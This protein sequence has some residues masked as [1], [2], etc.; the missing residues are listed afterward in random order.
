MQRVN[1]FYMSPNPYGGWVTFTAHLMT[2]LLRCGVDAHLFKIGNNTE[3][4]HRPFGYGKFYQNISLADA[5]MLD[6]E[7]LIVAMARNYVEAAAKL[8]DCNSARI[9]IHDPTELKHKSIPTWFLADHCRE[10]MV[11]IRKSMLKV[12]PGATYIP[13]PFE[14]TTTTRKVVKLKNAVSTCRID[15]DKHTEILLTANRLLPE[16]KRI[17]IRGF[18]N[19]LYTKFKIVP[20]FPEWVQSKAHYDR[21]QWGSVYEILRPATYAVDMSEIKGDG[22]GTQYSFLEAI[23]AGCVLVLNRKWMFDKKTDVMQ[24]DENCFM[25]SSGEEL[26]SLLEKPLHKDKQYQ[27]TQ[28]AEKILA[29]HEPKLIGTEYMRFLGG[30]R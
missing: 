8:I 10:K 12:L 6:G 20:N 21:S 25:V 18:E 29:K 24:E 5:V 27:L 7:H 19:R 9:V 26:A 15:F 2:A 13:H 17:D 28:R 30:S 22:G 16:N 23:D 14:R 3:S 1:L 4:K 11:V